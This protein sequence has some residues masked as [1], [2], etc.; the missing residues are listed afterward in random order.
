MMIWCV[1]N[2]RRWRCDMSSVWHGQAV[3]LDGLPVMCE[4]ESVDSILIVEEPCFMVS[5]VRNIHGKVRGKFI[6]LDRDLGLPDGEDVTVS[7]HRQSVESSDTY[8][9][10]DGIR[11]SAGGWAED[12]EEL[13]KYLEWNRQQ[14]KVT[15]TL[16]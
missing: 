1:R 15:R 11:N 10:G 16:Y 12:A 7:I 2:W 8:R 5:P 13:D 9:P 3:A 14:R 6:E 4:L